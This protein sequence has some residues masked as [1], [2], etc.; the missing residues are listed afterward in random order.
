ML[1]FDSFD[2]MRARLAAREQ[3]AEQEARNKDKEL[4]HLRAEVAR[5]TKLL[6][7]QRS[8]RSE[9]LGGVSRGFAHACGFGPHA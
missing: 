3:T 9:F 4:H 2:D 5:L 7:E 8:V 1:W 6:V